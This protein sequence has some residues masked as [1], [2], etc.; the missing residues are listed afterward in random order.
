RGVHLFPGKNSLEFH[1]RLIENVVARFKFN[2]VVLEC[3]YTQWDSARGIW[4]DF[5]VPKEQINAYVKMLRDNGLEPIPLVQSLG[6][7]EWMFKNGQNANLAEDPD[8]PYAY[9][10]WNPDARNFI[11][12]VYREALELFRPK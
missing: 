3:Q 6:H 10:A 9:D 12:N 4:V 5:S 8:R 2:H 11:G 7:C 1:R